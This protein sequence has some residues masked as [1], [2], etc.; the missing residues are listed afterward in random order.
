MHY[1][2]R[3]FAWDNCTKTSNRDDMFMAED[4]EFLQSVAGDKP[5]V[6]SI[7]EGL[8]SLEVVLKAQSGEC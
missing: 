8:K 4:L 1:N 3:S 2:R 6:C 5:I 7:V